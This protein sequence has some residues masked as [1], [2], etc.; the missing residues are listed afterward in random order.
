[1]AL[2]GAGY[3]TNL[4]VDLARF[5]VVD[6][7]VYEVRGD[8]PRLTEADLTADAR[9]LDITYSVDFSGSAEYLLPDSGSKIQLN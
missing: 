4:P 6:S 9:V 2:E 8:F 3:R 1:L 7:G 5:D